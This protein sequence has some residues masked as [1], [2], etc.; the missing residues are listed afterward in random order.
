MYANM[1]IY[2]IQFITHRGERMESRVERLDEHA[3]A[4]V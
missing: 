1:Y 2:M 4:G 3:E